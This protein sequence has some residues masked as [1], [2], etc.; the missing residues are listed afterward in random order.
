MVTD[1]DCAPGQGWACTDRV[2]GV[3]AVVGWHSY[4]GQGARYR[5]YDDGE[6]VIAFNPGNRGWVAFDNNPHGAQDHHGGDRHEGR[7]LLRHPPRRPAE[8]PVQRPDDQGARERQGDVTVEAL[9]AVAFTR[10]DRV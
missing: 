2:P 4:V 9:D 1:T 10:L 8:R 3:L 5:W 7:D 6:N